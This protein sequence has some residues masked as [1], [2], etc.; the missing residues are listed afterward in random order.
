MHGLVG[1]GI[2][3]LR[4]GVKLR[5]R[6]AQ[7]GS[8]VGNRLA[9]PLCESFFCSFT[10]DQTQSNSRNEHQTPDRKTIRATTKRKRVKLIGTGRPG[11]AAGVA[12]AVWRSK[13]RPATE[14][15]VNIHIICLQSKCG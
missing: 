6:C 4:R 9:L 8:N 11:K 13:G 14:N 1:D 7:V 2:D 3:E 5:V 15:V 12:A 10:R